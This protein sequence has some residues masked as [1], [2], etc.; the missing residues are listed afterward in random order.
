M[1]ITLI[2]GSPKSREG[3]SQLI[4]DELKKHFSAD[5]ISEMHFKLP[6]VTN[7][8]IE[9]LQKSDVLIFS[10][11]LYVDAVPSNLL[12]CLMTLEKELQ[13]LPIVVYAICNN[14]FYEGIQNK[15]ALDVIKNWTVKTHLR[16]GQG[17]GVG[18]GGLYSGLKSVPIGK[19]P[20]KNL[21]KALDVL[22]ENIHA[23]NS[24]ENVFISANIPRFFYKLVAHI[25]WRKEIKM[26]GKTTKDL[27]R[28]L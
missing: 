27:Y 8:E 10:F 16:W 26:N 3:T 11:P 2:N 17:I 9:T 20:K 19:G 13:S 5:S 25:G 1:K 14:G 15:Y 7:S 23:L 6:K 12:G 22:S 24:S 4:L 28:K 21:G 18:C